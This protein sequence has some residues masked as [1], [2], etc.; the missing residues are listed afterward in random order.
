MFPVSSEQPGL[1]LLIITEDVRPC[2]HFTEQEHRTFETTFQQKNKKQNNN[3][4]K[5]LFR[6]LFRS[7]INIQSTDKWNKNSSFYSII[8]SGSS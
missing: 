3:N 5:S 6:Q 4:R 8:L 2:L 1:L 7:I